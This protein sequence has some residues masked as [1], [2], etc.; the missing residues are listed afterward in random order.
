[1]FSPADSLMPTTLTSDSAMMTP[2]PKMTSPGAER[3]GSQNRPP[4]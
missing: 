1:M 4:R 3:S 2:A